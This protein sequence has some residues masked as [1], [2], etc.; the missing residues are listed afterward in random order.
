VRPLIEALSAAQAAMCGKPVAF[1]R[2]I[3]PAAT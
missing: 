2:L 1:Q 3:P